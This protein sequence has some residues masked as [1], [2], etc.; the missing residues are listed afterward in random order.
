MTLLNKVRSLSNPELAHIIHV[1]DRFQALLRKPPVDMPAVAGLLDDLDHP[2]RLAAVRSLKPRHLEHLYDAAGGFRRVGIDD[3]VPKARG[4]GSPVRH[5]GKNSL[6]AFTIFEKR[7]L[8]P[9]EDA[10][11]L[12]GYNHQTMSPLT[13]PGYFTAR[14]NPER[15]EVDIDYNHIP[16]ESPPG[17]PRLA[18]N[19]R[20]LG[21]L[22]YGYM[23]DRLRGIT[24]EVSIGR[25]WKRGKI[26][27]AWFVLCRE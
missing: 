3:L 17:W 8:R 1:T 4:A 13:G 19:T 22:V 23:I 14:D 2:V 7:F 9:A 21:R 16:P 27:K 20:G 10:R 12:W 24:G 25:A 26:Q 6:P 15:G 18:D 5:Y 11:E